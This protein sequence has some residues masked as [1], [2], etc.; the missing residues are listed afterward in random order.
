MQIDSNTIQNAVKNFSAYSAEI[1]SILS[2]TSDASPS[3]VSEELIQGILNGRT[4]SA[5]QRLVP[6]S[7]R[8]EA[9]L[10]FTSTDLANQVARELIPLL[11]NGTTVCDP[12]SGAG[13]L[14]LACAKYLPPGNTFNETLKNWSNCIS[15][16]DVFP[17]FIE[18]AKLRLLIAA[19]HLHHIC[20]NLR[21]I[22]TDKIF[23]G[24]YKSDIFQV[25]PVP[26]AK[27]FVL[28]PPFGNMPAPEGCVWATGNIQIAGWFLEKL[29]KSIPKGRHVVAILPDVL[30]SGSR[31]KKWR[32]TIS[33][34][35]SI[36]SIKNKGRFDNDT[37]VDVFILHF[38]TGKPGNSN[39]WYK[40]TPSPKKGQSIGEYFDVHV[41]AVVPHRNPEKG[42]EFP[43]IHARTALAWQTIDTIDERVKFSGTV[44]DP[45]FVIVHRTSS[46]S[47]KARCVASIVNTRSKVA[48][49]NHLLV[50]SPKRNDMASC[51][52]LLN[53]LRNSKT[54]RWLNIRI[55]CRHLTT[56]SLSELPWWNIK[57]VKK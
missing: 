25:K 20:I 38:L 45:P 53:V 29:L 44:F 14:L 35:G 4:S 31:Y 2:T 7:I 22:A 19:A 10:F 28:N 16:Y 55:R 33:H 34:Y 48:V 36:L 1:K 11:K 5:L 41:G 3:L 8:K 27:C 17:E 13:N 47:D 54:N 30:R 56:S 40:E 49:E 43:Y 37:D 21:G 32:D 26:A 39:E 24:L 23:T 9:G 15:G 12:A 42:M 50:L 6:L 51:K 18:A 57:V 46:P 52:K